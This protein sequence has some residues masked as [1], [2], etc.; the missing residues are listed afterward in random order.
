[1]PLSSANNWDSHLMVE[2]TVNSSLSVDYFELAGAVSVTG[3]V[4]SVD[5]EHNVVVNDVY[6]NGLE[7]YLLDCLYTASNNCLTEENAAVMCQG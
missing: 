6:C 2:E 4:Y 7:D 1:M 5:G 3:G